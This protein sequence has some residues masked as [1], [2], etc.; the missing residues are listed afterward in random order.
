M[1]CSCSRS[2]SARVD[3]PVERDHA[4]E[5][6]QRVA[7]ERL[8]VGLE[9][10][11]ADRHPAGVVVLDDHAGRRLELVEQAARRVEVEHVVEGERLAVQLRRPARARGE[12]SPDLDVERRPLVRV[13]AVGEVEHLLVGDHQVLREVLVAQP[14]PAADRGV[15][16][17]GLARTPRWRAS[18]GSRRRSRRPTPPARRAPRRSSPASRPPR[19]SAWFLA[20]ARI[21]VGPP[22]SMFSTASV[23]GHV[24]AGDRALERVEVHA[25]EVDRL[26]PLGSERRHVLGV[27]A[28]APAAPRAAAGAASSP[29][30]RGSPASR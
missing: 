12:R 2:A 18:A 8:L 19:R 21:I 10:V 17:R 28:H 5:G 1:K 13:L 25:D 22:M 26:D 14:E 15:V 9:R 7:G 4:A 6:R 16:A 27:V 20:A 3:R 11:V 24:A 30:R 29:G 23:L